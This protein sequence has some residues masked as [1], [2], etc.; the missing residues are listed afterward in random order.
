[1][2][3]GFRWQLVQVERTIFFEVTSQVARRLVIGQ[4]A[5]SASSNEKGVFRPV[6]DC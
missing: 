5:I 2:T 4:R 3:R 1:M 6:G